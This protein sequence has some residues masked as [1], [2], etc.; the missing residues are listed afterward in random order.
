MGV[1]RLDGGLG[2]M[3]SGRWRKEE[4]RE[5]PT[6]CSHQ[7][8]WA[9]HRRGE[10]EEEQTWNADTFKDG[11]VQTV[12]VLC[13][14]RSVVSSTWG[15]VGRGRGVWGEWKEARCSDHSCRCGE[16]RRWV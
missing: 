5:L 4:R 15:G 10:G 2:T 11:P 1:W 9:D 12:P 16:G 13:T 3:S 7:L 14:S 8:P 6:S